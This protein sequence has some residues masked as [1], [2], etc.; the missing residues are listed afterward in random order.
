MGNSGGVIL[1]GIE[2]SQSN[3][4]LSVTAG[5]AVI[6]KEVVFMPT[7]TLSISNLSDVYLA[8]DVSYDANGNDEFA[9]LVSRD[10]HEIRRGKIV[11]SALAP[12]S[13]ITLSSAHRIKE[14]IN[15]Y[16]EIPNISDSIHTA[17]GRYFS[18]WSAYIEA[19]QEI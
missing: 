19:K 7:Q 5:Y 15:D 1:S 14:A 2:L 8:F 12:I 4:E 11:E 17:S 16:V 13:A 3:S 6:G 18:N 9:D 10:T